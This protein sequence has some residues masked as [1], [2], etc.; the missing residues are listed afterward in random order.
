MWN[1]RNLLFLQRFNGCFSQL[2]QAEWNG[3]DLEGVVSA[4][5]HGLVFDKADIDRLIATNRD[6]MW[7]Q[8]F[9][10]ATFQ[11]IDGR[12]PDERWKNSPGVLWSALLPYDETLRKAFIANHNPSG[13]GALSA[14]PWFLA[15]FEQD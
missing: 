9:D 7:N 5:E 14:T 13:W 4:Y 1:W 6:F 2:F 11:R 10:G 3:I 12:E 8:K 15:G